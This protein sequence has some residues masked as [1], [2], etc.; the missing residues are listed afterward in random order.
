MNIDVKKHL[1]AIG[2]IV[3]KFLAD[4]GGMHNGY[5][6]YAQGTVTINE[7][8]SLVIRTPAM[9]DLTVKHVKLLGEELHSQ[10][11]AYL[12]A[13]SLV[14]CTIT[15]S[16]KYFEHGCYEQRISYTEE[17]DIRVPTV[18]KL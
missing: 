5:D 2:K 14:D 10:I 8:G 11:T 16:G 6:T 12:R 1:T 9:D 18:R 13:Q 3:G 15:L 7:A 17:I 4:H